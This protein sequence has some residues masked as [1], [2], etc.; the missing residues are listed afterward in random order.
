MIDN[1]RKKELRET[2]K[3]TPRTAGIIAIRNKKNGKVFIAASVN[4]NA[5][6][7]KSKAVLNFGSHL[8][9]ALQEEWNSY[10]AESFEIEILDTLDPEE[11]MT[12]VPADDVNELFDL[13]FTKLEPYGD[14]GYHR[15]E[16]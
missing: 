15:F 1:E 14:K 12:E 4:V 7:N 3:Q 9:S 8:N 16:K 11:H 2:Y 6:I 13:W 5:L 10:G